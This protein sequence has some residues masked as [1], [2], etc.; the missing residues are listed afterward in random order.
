MSYN[1]YIKE[2]NRITVDGEVETLSLDRGINLLYGDPNTG[3]TF[4][5]QL[6]DFLLGDRGTIEDAFSNDETLLDKYTA[7]NAVIEIE[8]ID[9]IIERNWNEPGKK[10]KI[11]LK[12]EY[13]SPDDFSKEICE[14]LNIELLH[15]PKGNPYV[16]TWPQ[17]SFRMMLRHIYRQERFWSDISDKQPKY[18]QDAVIA[19]FLGYANKIYSNEENDIVEKNKKLI[20]LEAQKAQF[21]ETL[22]SITREMT[23][24]LEGYST[25]LITKD[26]IE[27]IITKLDKEIDDNLEYREKFVE[28][29]R[30]NEQDD[31]IDFDKEQI[32]TQQRIMLFEHKENIFKQRNE[33][34]NRVSEFTQ[35][36]FTMESEISKLSRSQES[37][38]ISSFPISHCPSCN[39]SI[40]SKQNSDE[41]FVCH[42]PIEEN[43]ELFDTVNFEKRNLI[44]EKEELHELIE[45]SKAE[46]Q[47]YDNQIQRIDEKLASLSSEIRPLRNK[48]SI[49]TNPELSQIDSNR[50]RLEE[51]VVNFKRLSNNLDIRDNLILKI[52]KLMEEISEIDKELEI[53]KEVVNYERIATVLE[54]AMMDYL[55]KISRDHSDRWNGKRISISLSENSVYFYVGKK[56]WTSLSATYKAYFLLAYHYGLLSLSNKS[57]FNYPGLLIL[58]FPFSFEDTD[59]TEFGHLIEP[60]Q[61]LCENEE[62]APQV[63]VTGR[64]FSSLEKANHIKLTKVWI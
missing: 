45:I 61:E 25:Q 53:K 23:S 36:R 40:K 56:K 32:V 14:L 64:R 26:I 47:E 42:Q 30:Q 29:L 4:W 48:S 37:S 15:I 52:D 3:K 63:I 44:A 21:N 50:G 11:K 17:L 22:D 41:C 13:L 35:L 34:L 57:D 2:I 60:F 46:L 10:T 31:K 8:G 5:I 33:L 19:Q 16:N 12:D 38:I 51:R 58:D 1:L 39:Q 54:D 43:N 27:E 20:K 18:E 28:Q 62:I 7:V 49:F 9:Y 59:I 6:L 24:K 55:Q